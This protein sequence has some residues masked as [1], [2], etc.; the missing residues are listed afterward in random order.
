MRI[1]KLTPGGGGGSGTPGGGGR[2]WGMPTSVLRAIG[3][4][5]VGPGGGGGGAGCELDLP[6]PSKTSRSDPPFSLMRL[7]SYGL[8]GCLWGLTSVHPCLGECRPYGV[9]GQG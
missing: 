7:Y 3:S 5:P 8:P 6:S 4:A 9:L 1:G 2:A